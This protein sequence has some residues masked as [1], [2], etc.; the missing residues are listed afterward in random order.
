MLRALAFI[1]S[2]GK[3]ITFYRTQTKKNR[4]FRIV[5]VGLEMPRKVLY[6]RINHRVDT[7]MANGLLKEAQ[8]LY[9]KR[10]LKNLQTVG[11]VELFDFLD[12]K[13]TLPE[14]IDKIKQHTRNYAK[15]QLT[16][17]KKDPGFI[18]FSPDKPGLIE[19]ILAL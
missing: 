4:P 15:R 8:Q 13:C 12:N 18:W 16:W 2:N 11:Y 14:A 3:S 5:K 19:E 9:P 6:N 17:F 10:H 1:R 7:M